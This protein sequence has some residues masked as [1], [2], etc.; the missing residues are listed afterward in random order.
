ML[1]DDVIVSEDALKVLF[2]YYEKLKASFHEILLSSVA[3]IDLDFKKPLYSFLKYNSKT[4]LTEK[5][6]DECFLEEYFEYDIAPMH[7]LF[8]PKEVLK[9]VGFFNGKLWGWYDDTEFVLR[10]KR[11]G[12]KGFAIT[13]SRIYH[14]VEFRKQVKIL[15]RTFNL[16]SGRPFRM[17]LGTRNNIYVQNSS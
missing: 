2:D 7:G 8:I 4:G 11:K 14:P 13:E 12:F 15:G 16:L 5:V 3:Y 10:C 1:D 17:Y 9:T 6:K